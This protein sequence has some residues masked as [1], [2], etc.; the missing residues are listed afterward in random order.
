M[1]EFDT[2]RF[3]VEIESRP[4]L[5][6]FEAPEYANKHLKTKA[7][8]ED[9]KYRFY[10]SVCPCVPGHRSETICM[11]VC[12][13]LATDL[14]RFVS[15]FGCMSLTTDLKLF[16][17]LSVCLSLAT[18]LK[19]FVFL[20]GCMSLT[21]DLKLFGCLSVCLSLATD[22]KRFVSLFGCMSLTTDLKLFGCLFA[23]LSLTIDLKRFVCLFVSLFVCLPV[24]GHRSKMICMY[25]CLS[26]PSH[27]SK[28]LKAF[29]RCEDEDIFTTVSPVSTF[30]FWATGESS[31]LDHAVTKSDHKDIDCMDICHTLK[32][33]TEN[34]HLGIQMVPAG[35]NKPMNQCLEITPELIE[36]FQLG[37]TS[38]SDRVR[39]SNKHVHHQASARVAST[40]RL[41]RRCAELIFQ[42]ERSPILVP[43]ERQ[44]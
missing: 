28:T 25:V 18:D 22:L 24:Y 7:W 13:S 20:F 14:K 27:R 32:N 4:A 44:L 19:R 15:L 11:S 12:L 43:R 8:D 37:Y 1:S 17:C 35:R 41:W 31:A 42:G 9:T 21:T 26:V 6:D 3:I 29:E 38:L 40:S 36:T 16:G 10:H 5:W 2:D 39:R 33:V 34:G 30:A 23:C